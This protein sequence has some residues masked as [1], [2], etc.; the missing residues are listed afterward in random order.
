MILVL[1]GY[2]V[3]GCFFLGLVIGLGNFPT[4]QYVDYSIPEAPLVQEY[5]FRA[6]GEYGFIS[7]FLLVSGSV[8]AVS[9]NLMCIQLLYQSSATKRSIFGGEREVKEKTN[10][11]NYVICPQCWNRLPENSKFCPRCGL[12][13]M[14]DSSRIPEKIVEV[15]ATQS[16]ECT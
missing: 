3:L 14:Q 9:G 6:G 4:N 10:T 1:A 12:T 11:I 15:E 7:L 5:D 8:L 13:L 16:L 2:G